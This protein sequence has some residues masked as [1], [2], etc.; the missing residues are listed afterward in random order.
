MDS[1]GTKN[2]LTDR[3]VYPYITGLALM[4]SGH[5]A[6]VWVKH[7]KRAAGKSQYNLFKLTALALR[8]LFTYSSYPLRLVSMIGLAIATCSFLFGAYFFGG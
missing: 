7:Q 8:I 2:T 6:N 5:P 4:F 3:T 1:N